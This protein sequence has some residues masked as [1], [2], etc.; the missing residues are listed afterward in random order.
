MENVYYGALFFHGVYFSF[1]FFNRQLINYLRFQI[2]LHHMKLDHCYIA[3]IKD[4][5]VNENIFMYVF[6][7]QSACMQSPYIFDEF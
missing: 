7:L 6:I 3:K 1:N 2:L 4:E 5:H